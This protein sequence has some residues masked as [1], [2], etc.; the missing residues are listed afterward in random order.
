MKYVGIFLYYK[1]NFFINVG[2]YNNTRYW[3][4]YGNLVPYHKINR[5]SVWKWSSCLF[6]VFKMANSFKY[7]FCS[8]EVF[9]NIYIL[10]VLYL[11]F[12]KNYF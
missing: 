3:T 12:A 6:Q 4:E 8:R 2:T 1:I 10:F 7:Y 11:Y 5:R 9:F